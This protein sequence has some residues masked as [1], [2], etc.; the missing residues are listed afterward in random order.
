MTKQLLSRDQRV[1]ILIWLA[2]ATC[3]LT[4]KEISAFYYP[5]SNIVFQYDST[6]EAQPDTFA[7]QKNR[8]F[9]KEQLVSLEINSADSN[10]N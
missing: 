5:T 9:Q 2:I 1:S 6:Y 10:E 7:F 4:Y 3:Y 8:T